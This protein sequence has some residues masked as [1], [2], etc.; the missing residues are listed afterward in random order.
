MDEV[1]VDTVQGHRELAERVQLGL[2]G[3]PIVVVTPVV[4]QLLEIRQV[5][6]VLPASIRNLVGPADSGQP[7]AQILEDVVGDSDGVGLRIH[8][9]LPWLPFSLPV[10]P[11]A[12]T[13]AGGPRTPLARGYQEVQRRSALLAG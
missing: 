7:S 9:V 10:V 6:T 4:D 3:P 12:D 5:R 2:L 11:G 8:S 13:A 1:H